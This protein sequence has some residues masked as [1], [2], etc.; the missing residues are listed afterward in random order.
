[1]EEQLH[2][3]DIDDGV[4]DYALRRFDTLNQPLGEMFEYK[5]RVLL[6]EM[7]RATLL[8]ATISERQLY[9]VMVQFWADHFNINPSK[10]G[11]CSAPGLG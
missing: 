1:M 10:A 11:A 3:E 9:E 4:T 8:R 2:P 6:D 7:T 5:E